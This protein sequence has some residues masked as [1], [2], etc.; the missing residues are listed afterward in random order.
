V[1]DT[2]QIVSI[3]Q[4]L[5][6]RDGANQSLGQVRR[7]EAFYVHERALAHEFLT[8]SINVE[9]TQTLI[10]RAISLPREHVLTLRL[11]AAGP[12]RRCNAYRAT[13]D[14][15]EVES[16]GTRAARRYSMTTQM[17]YSGAHSAASLSRGARPLHS[18]ANGNK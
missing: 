12:L 2:G 3:Y 17:V 6:R 5:D 18:V 15:E 13:S 7:Q 11:V 9:R 16:D 1:T 10:D 14:V 4:A 8:Q